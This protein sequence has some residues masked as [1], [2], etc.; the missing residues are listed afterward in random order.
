MA[1]KCNNLLP[2]KP[3]K[4]TNKIMINPQNNALTNFLN[5]N[6]LFLKNLIVCLLPSKYNLS[7]LQRIFNEMLVL[8]TDQYIGSYINEA[9]PIKLNEFQR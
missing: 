5:L 3:I 1:D 8:A 7:W 4:I 9:N 6:L 2:E